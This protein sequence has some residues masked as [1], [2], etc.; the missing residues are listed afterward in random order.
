MINNVPPNH[1]LPGSH[2]QQPTGPPYCRVRRKDAQRL[3]SRASHSAVAVGQRAPRDPL[4]QGP[5]ELSI[6]AQSGRQRSLA[7]PPSLQARVMSRVAL[8]RAALALAALSCA[9]GG[10]EHRWR[11]E[12]PGAATHF[13]SLRHGV[14]DVRVV[15][16]GEEV[17]GSSWARSE[18]RDAMRLPLQLEDHEGSLLV[19]LDATAGGEEMDFSLSMPGGVFASSGNASV[20]HRGCGECMGDRG[21]ESSVHFIHIP[22]AAGTTIEE[23]GCRNGLRWGKCSSNAGESTV[24]DLAALECSAWHRPLREPRHR[25][26]AADLLDAGHREIGREIGASG[27]CRSFCV[28]R[29]PFDR[30]LSEFRFRVTRDEIAHRYDAGGL[31]SWISELAGAG[32]TQTT[33]D[34]T[35]NIVDFTLKIMVF[36]LE[37]MNFTLKMMG[38]CSSR[39]A[40]QQ[41]KMLILY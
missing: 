28:M 3:E 18:M 7:Q 36:T 10:G 40:P 2:D 9:Q 32:Q 14:D 4:L 22:K 38:F 17:A 1:L 13:V 30:I 8:L 41:V 15:L 12:T 26:S 33:T 29:E 39:A 5:L 37:I 11:W 23:V 34:F 31:S 24:E 35:L 6:R 25:R 27:G 16:D 21:T 20:R 19:Q